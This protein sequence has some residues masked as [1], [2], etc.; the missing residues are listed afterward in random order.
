MGIVLANQSRVK[1]D[2]IVEFKE[3][4]VPILVGILFIL[5]AANVDVQD[6]IDLGWRGL[7]LVAILVVVVRPLAVASLFGL[8]FARQERVFFAAMAPR[9]IVAASTASAFGLS[10]TE[11]GVKG[12]EM[13]IPITFFVIVGT[14]LIY[15]LG[16]P[17]LAQVP[18]ALRESSHRP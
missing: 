11:Q 5:L 6:V 4:L 3:T 1:T 17:S 2:Y 13:V 7:V 9:G 8:P 10:L 15:A 12:A 14:V 16:S 18:R